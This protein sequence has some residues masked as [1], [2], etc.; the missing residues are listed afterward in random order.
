V[1]GNPYRHDLPGLRRKGTPDTGLRARHGAPDGVRASAA[2]RPSGDDR[3]ARQLLPIGQAEP[4]RCADAPN[5][6]FA[7]K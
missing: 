6:A 3:N 5:A 7:S 2:R 1:Y 4:V